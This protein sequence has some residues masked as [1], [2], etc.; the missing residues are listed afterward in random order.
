[1]QILY[2]HPNTPQGTSCARC[3]RKPGHPDDLEAFM[4]GHAWRTREPLPGLAAPFWICAA[5]ARD[6]ERP[7]TAAETRAA[8]LAIGAHPASWDPYGGG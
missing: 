6:D 3:G 5:C 1:M 7:E 4:E 8:W 2:R